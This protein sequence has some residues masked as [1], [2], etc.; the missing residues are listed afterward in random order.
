MESGERSLLAD[1]FEDIIEIAWSPNGRQI[2]VHDQGRYRIQVMNADG[3]DLHV[4]LA[5][6]DACCETDWSPDGDRILY[7]LSTGTVREG[8]LGL[9]D[10]E[11]WTVSP[12]GSNRTK[13]FDSDG[14]DMGR[15]QM[16]F[17]VWAPNGTQ[18]AYNAC[19][20]WVVEDADGSGDPQPI[21][22]L[23]WRSWYSGGLSQWD[24]AGIGQINR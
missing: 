24:L 12:D 10:S 22:E 11:V 16:L 18:V 23:L 9:F 5:G 17:P 15:N 21:D 3:S 13:V 8:R 20:D 14:C 4:L 7:M 2:L 6:E 19:G 1:S